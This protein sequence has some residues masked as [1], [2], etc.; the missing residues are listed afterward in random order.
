MPFSITI[1]TR[2][3]ARC[4]LLS[5]VPGK[6]NKRRGLLHGIVIASIPNGKFRVHFNAIVRNADLSSKEMTV[7]EESQPVSSLDTSSIK[8]LD[9]EKYY[10]GDKAKLTRWVDKNCGHG[11]LQAQTQPSSSQSSSTQESPSQQIDAQDHED[12]QDHTQH[13][14]AIIAQVATANR[15]NAERRMTGDIPTGTTENSSSV[16]DD[17]AQSDD[18]VVENVYSDDEDDDNN[19]YIHVRENLDEN[20]LREDIVAETRDANYEEKTVRYNNE[21]ASLIGSTITVGKNREKT[22]QIKKWIP[23]L[24]ARD[25]LKSTDEWWQIVQVFADFNENRRSVLQSSNYKVDDETISAF[26][27]QTRKNGNLPHLSFIQRKPE[28]LGTEFKSCACGVLGMML[29]LELQRGKDDNTCSKFLR[30]MNNKKAAACTL[31]LAEESSQRD[32]PANDDSLNPHHTEDIHIADSWFGSVRTL[33]GFRKFISHKTKGIMNIKQCSSCYPKKF[34]EATMQSWPAGS[35]IVLSAEVDDVK[36]FAIGYK[37]CSKKTMCFLMNDGSASTEGGEPYR[38]KWNDENGNNMVK[39]VPRPEACSTYF[40]FSNVIDVLNSLRQKELR[41]E[42]HWV[43]Q[44]GYFR[45]IT[46]IFGICVV[47]AWKGYKHHLKCTRHRHK[48]CELMEF[49]DML[50]YD[51]LHNEL[52]DKVP[53][54]AALTIAP[55]MVRNDNVPNIESPPRSRNSFQTEVPEHNP[56]TPPQIDIQ[57]NSLAPIAGSELAI[58][59]QIDSE[60]RQHKLVRNEEWKIERRQRGDGRV[61]NV[62]RR[63]RGKC[64][65]CKDDNN[66]TLFYCECCPPPPKAKRFWVCH[67]DSKNG[68][69]CLAAHHES[70][71]N[72]F[73]TNHIGGHNSCID[74]IHL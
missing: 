67:P 8:S 43:T 38:A 15:A 30:E 73:I 58:Q 22:E 48:D 57:Q 32:L 70:V 61:R 4:G 19:D 29:A 20:S 25:D 59:G 24:W 9:I 46:T 51:C 47:D 34:I 74:D 53:E 21:K 64:T 17:T 14:N 2:I 6:K 10:I 56:I 54:K 49:V 60:L 52:P 26:R 66:K 31:R 41:L 27:P 36:M 11:P 23:F 16:G 44:D 65:I 28:D 35:H 37:Y 71:R 18:I 7:L 33:K 5:P 72:E 69:A 1:G 39:L 63:K 68:G 45:I 3:S 13:A 42:K 12:P 62:K 55:V 50:A 40:H